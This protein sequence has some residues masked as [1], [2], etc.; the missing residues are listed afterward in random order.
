MDVRDNPGGIMEAA[1][2]LDYIFADD[3]NASTMNLHTR[4]RQYH[5]SA[6]MPLVE[7][8]IPRSDGTGR[9]FPISRFIFRGLELCVPFA[10]PNTEYPKIPGRFANT[11]IVVLQNGGSASGAEWFLAMARGPLR[12]KNPDR[13]TLIG[14]RS[15]GKGVAQR[16][17]PLPRGEED[18]NYP[19]V[20]ITIMEFRSSTAPDERIQGVGIEPDIVVP[21][22]PAS[23]D[24]Q[25]ARAL[26]VLSR[27]P[28][29]AESQ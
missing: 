21:R 18:A 20:H 25:L 9:V 12:V 27:D 3:I 1:I 23:Y 17:I 16:V 5:L 24:L 13:V 10:D 28:A 4:S 26:E 11:R 14:T 22:G 6:K 29:P 2:E 8:F 7:C 15:F 19:L